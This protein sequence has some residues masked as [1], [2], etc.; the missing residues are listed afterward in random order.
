MLL[1]VGKRQQCSAHLLVWY[2]AP[3]CGD[4]A[5]AARGA[6]DQLRRADL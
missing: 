4:S 3:A 1:F 6:V 5:G 2:Q